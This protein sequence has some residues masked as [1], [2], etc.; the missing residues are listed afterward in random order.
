VHRIPL[1]TQVVALLQQQG[2]RKAGVIFPGT[3]PG[4]PLST[5]A[6]RSAIKRMEKAGLVEPDA[7]TPHGVARAGFKSWAADQDGYD[8]DVTEACLSHVIGDK[9]EAA[10]R[11]TDF[12]TKRVKLMQAWADY[13]TE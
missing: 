5:N 12:Y 9:I 3:K 4:K 6:M 7:V 10:Y 1:S 8:K 13:V 11:R 2:P